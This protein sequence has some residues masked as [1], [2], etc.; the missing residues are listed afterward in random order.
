MT[1]NELGKL[2]MGELDVLRSNFSK[3]F[4]S[5]KFILENTEH[6]LDRIERGASYVLGFFGAVLP[7]FIVVN[8]PARKNFINNDFF[9]MY[10]ALDLL[11]VLSVIVVLIPKKIFRIVRFTFNVKEKQ[12]NEEEEDFKIRVVEDEIDLIKKTVN[13]ALVPMHISIS[14][15]AVIGE[16]FA[17]LSYLYLFILFF[18]IFVDQAR[19]FVPGLFSFF[20]FTEVWLISVLAPLLFC[21]Y[22]GMKEWTKL[23]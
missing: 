20:S 7:F 8:E 4:D 3:K 6:T 23:K 16:T 17:K 10:L 13:D 11:V 12:N 18:Y 22:R 21:L 9:F 2:T 19:K 1:E 15:N 5:S 14:E